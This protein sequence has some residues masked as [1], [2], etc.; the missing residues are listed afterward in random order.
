MRLILD[1]KGNTSYATKYRAAYSRILSL[2]MEETRG[3]MISRSEVIP[4]VGLCSWHEG[5]G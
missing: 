1:D 2:L 5:Y 4:K 3:R